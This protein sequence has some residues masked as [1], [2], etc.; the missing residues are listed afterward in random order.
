MNMNIFF[1]IHQDLPREGPGDDASTAKAY[2]MLQGLPPEPHILDV[3]CGPGMQTRCLV[4]LSGGHITAVDTRQEFLDVLLHD[5]GAE[6]LSSHILTRQMSMFSLDL[7]AESFDI[8]WSEGAI[9]IMG[10]GEG[11]R[12]WRTLLKPGGW[13]AVTELTWIKPQPPQEILSFWQTE[14]PAMK[15]VE[16]NLDLVRTAGYRVG[17]HFT[18]PD[19]SWTASY[20]IPME[21]RLVGLRE[22]YQGQP[23]ALAAIEE[24]QREIEMFRKYSAWYGY[25]FYVMQKE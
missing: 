21:K 17:G 11:L 6:G 24:N 14:Y 2:A 1:E 13:V 5:A 22:K 23:E 8:I 7:D 9:Y 10:F 15:T 20:Y 18:L 4:L 16:E 12:A 3:G 25:V 19:E